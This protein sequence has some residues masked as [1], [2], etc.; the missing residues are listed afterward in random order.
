ME[1]KFLDKS[2]QDWR[3]IYRRYRANLIFNHAIHARVSG[4]YVMIHG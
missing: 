2:V 1:E 3:D 4:I